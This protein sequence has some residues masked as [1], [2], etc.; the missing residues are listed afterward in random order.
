VSGEDA[1]RPYLENP[2]VPENENKQTNKQTLKSLKIAA[3]SDLSTCPDLVYDRC[4]PRGCSSIRTA[5]VVRSNPSRHRLTSMV[6]S[7]RLKKLMPTATQICTRS[8]SLLTSPTA[9]LTAVPMVLSLKSIIVT[10]VLILSASPSATAPDWQSPRSCSHASQ[11]WTLVTVVLVLSASANATA[12]TSPIP[13]VVK[14]MFLVPMV[15]SRNTDG[16]LL[17]D[18]VSNKIVLHNEAHNNKGKFDYGGGDTFELRGSTILPIIDSEDTSAFKDYVSVA[19]LKPRIS[20]PDI[21][22]LQSIVNLKAKIR[23]ILSSRRENGNKSVLR[24]PA[25]AASQR[26]FMVALGVVSEVVRSSFSCD[27]LVLV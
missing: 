1:P 14:G 3:L 24:G 18:S 4:S 10:A 16:G 20:T 7:R 9:R 8:A 22:G 26:D 12:P 27:V 23:S 19:T 13:V 25:N 15:F 5:Y 11:S 17:Y 21:N 6:E 2:I